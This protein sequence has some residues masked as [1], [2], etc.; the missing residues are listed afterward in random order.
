M[1]MKLCTVGDC[2]G[3]RLGNSQ[4]CLMHR[5]LSKETVNLETNSNSQEQTNSW[6]FL[7][8]ILLS[9]L[10]LIIGDMG[11]SAQGGWSELGGNLSGIF[12]CCLG[13]IIILPFIST[14][15]HK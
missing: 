12:V 5:N 8:L 13:F 2:N 9:M 10:F 1:S 14:S 6:A 3:P 15:K 7:L 4:Y 11:M